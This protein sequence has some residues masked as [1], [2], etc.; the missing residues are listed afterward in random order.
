MLLCIEFV[1]H[2][3]DRVDGCLFVIVI[4]HLKKITII[5]LNLTFLEAYINQILEIVE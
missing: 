4:F 2:L 1:F 3:M 5:S